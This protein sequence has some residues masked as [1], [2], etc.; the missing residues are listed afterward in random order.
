[1][2]QVKIGKVKVRH[3]TRV[4]KQ[5]LLGHMMMRWLRYDNETHSVKTR[6]YR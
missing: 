4:I 2:Q 6:W 1:M 5:S 3:E